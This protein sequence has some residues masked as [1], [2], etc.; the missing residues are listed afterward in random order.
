VEVLLDDEDNPLWVT[1]KIAIV[2]SVLFFKGG[3]VVKR[4]DGVARVGLH[5]E[6][7]GTALAAFDR[8]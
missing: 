3:K 5:A 8:R 2:P 1:Y 6:E 7:L 4:L